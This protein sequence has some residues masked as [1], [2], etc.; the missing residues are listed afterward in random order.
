MKDGHIL[1]AGQKAKPRSPV[2]PGMTVEITVPA[3]EELDLIPQDIPLQVLH[4][5]DEFIVINKA[6]G[7]VV[8]PAAGNPDGT[9]VNALL[10]HCAGQ[11]AGIGGVERPGIVHRLDKDTSGVIIVAKTDRAHQSLAGQ[12]ADRKTLKHYL[13]VA[14]GE[15]TDLPQTVF[16][17]IARHRVNRQQ[18]AVCNPGAGKP[19]ITDVHHLHTAPDG[20]ALLLCALHTG[21]THQIRVHTKHLG[22][23]LLGDPIY[24]KPARQPAHLERLHLHAWRLGIN[25]PTTGHWHVFEAPIP[26]EFHRHTDEVPQKLT[27]L[28]KTGKEDKLEDL[29]AK[30]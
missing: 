15:P 18:M 10:H 2:A 27:A 25:H 24:S 17:H 14:Q 13:A 4:D 20:T 19:A 30:L 12:F 29:L 22:H 11:L 7:M 8:H 26:P 16:T 9:L 23:P 3:P 28:R 21:R 5:D 1:L 6:P